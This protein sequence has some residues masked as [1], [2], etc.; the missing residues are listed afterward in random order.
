[1]QV[2]EKVNQSNGSLKLS[3]QNQKI[4][5]AKKYPIEPDVIVRPSTPY[6]VPQN[7]RRHFNK[8]SHKTTLS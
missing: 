6:L 1:M 7:T 3:Q 8:H 2:V 5:D 4:L